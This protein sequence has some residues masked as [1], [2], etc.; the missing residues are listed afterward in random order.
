MS[1][2][3]QN[4]SRK[5]RVDKNTTQLK[6]DTGNKK[7]YKVK[8]IWNSAVYARETEEYLLG[9]YYLILWKDYPKE[10]NTGEPAL[11]V[12]HLQKLINT[13]H[14]DYLSKPIATSSLINIPSPISKPTAKSPATKKK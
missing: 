11:A 6:C 12:E 4:S 2:Q 8:Q 3:E 13:F 5:E 7:E 10:K 1:L 14:K 9:L